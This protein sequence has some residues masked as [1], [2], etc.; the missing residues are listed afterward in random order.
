L[1]ILNN[2]SIIINILF[3]LNLIGF[4]YYL[5][6]ILKIL[7]ITELLM[8]FINLNLLITSISI[9][10]LIGQIFTLFILA[11]IAAESAIS[12]V[13][14]INFYKKKNSINLEYINSIK[15]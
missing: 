2:F 15:G 5:K 10:D 8:L 7:I 13:I 4:F 1:L 14:I 11:I 3:L 9:D 6:N 12:L